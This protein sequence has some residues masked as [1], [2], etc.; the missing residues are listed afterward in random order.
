MNNKM[1]YL[2]NKFV[3][4]LLVLLLNTN[5]L[6]ADSKNEV[7]VFPNNYPEVLEKAK[8]GEK[9]AQEEI[10]KIIYKG[11]MRYP[12]ANNLNDIYHFCWLDAIHQNDSFERKVARFFFTN[13]K[14]KDA[15]QT[16]LTIKE[17]ASNGDPYAQRAMGSCYFY[18]ELVDNSPETG[19]EWYKKSAKQGHARAQMSLALRYLGGIYYVRKNIPEG[20]KWLKMAADAGLP[21]AQYELCGRHLSGDNVPLDRTSAFNL[22]LSSAKG[23]DLQAQVDLALFHLG[24]IKEEWPILQNT[25][26]GVYWLTKA[27]KSGD[28][29]ALVLLGKYYIIGKHVEQN[30]KKGREMLEKAAAL[31]HKAA[32]EEC[33][34]IK[35]IIL[36]GS[37]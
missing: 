35:E 12:D 18:T 23:G 29:N 5:L 15:E 3:I 7:W 9:P 16:L 30:L 8:E 14:A 10:C 1:I 11:V 17:K 4:F 31:G 20:M 19:I 36:S 24:L 6:R 28:L 21:E 32:R 26:E 13:G 2:L 25:L 34:A 33:K 27:A 22:L 37:S